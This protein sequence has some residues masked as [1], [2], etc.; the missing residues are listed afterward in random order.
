VGRR[1]DVAAVAAIGALVVGAVL[2]LVLA[3]VPPTD[4]ISVLRQTISQYGVSANKWVFN[5]A[6]LLVAVASAV[7]LAVLRRQRRLP[8]LALV[9]GVLWTVCLLVIVVFPRSTRSIAE[10][11]GYGGTLHRAASAVG[12]VCLPIAVLLAVGVAFPGSPGRRV[13]ARVFALLALAW[14]GVILVAIVIAAVGHGHWWTI[15]PLGLVE[16]GLALT[17]LIALALLAAPARTDAQPTGT[18]AA[19][20]RTDAPTRADPTRRG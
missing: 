6:V 12:F 3:F 4:Q 1:S 8:G 7:I 9:F 17:G 2:I 5:V 15:I 20:T 13:W 10:G 16:R 11:F 18:D 14:F 19:S